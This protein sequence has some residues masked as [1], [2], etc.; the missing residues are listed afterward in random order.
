MLTVSEKRKKR[1]EH[2]RIWLIGL[3]AQTQHQSYYGKL[4]ITMED[5]CIRRV[6]KEESL[7][8]PYEDT[9]MEMK[10]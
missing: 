1:E 7:K 2:E 3:L 6:V 4:I 10:K 8:P 5:G 9:P